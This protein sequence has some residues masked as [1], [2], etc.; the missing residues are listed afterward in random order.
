M[1]DLFIGAAL[2]VMA[3]A[4]LAAECVYLIPHLVSSHSVFGVLLGLV[5]IV[6][7][8]GTLAFVVAVLLELIAEDDFGM[9]GGE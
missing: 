5:L 3:F 1:K 8:V 2:A 7:A 6:Q 9:G 4:A